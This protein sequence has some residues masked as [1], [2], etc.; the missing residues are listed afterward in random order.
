MFPVLSVAALSPR[1]F[2][3]LR[4]P[5]SAAVEFS[6]STRKHSGPFPKEGG[7][8]RLNHSRDGRIPV[9]NALTSNFLHRWILRGFCNSSS[10]ARH[11]TFCRI[12]SFS[13]V[14]ISDLKLATTD[15]FL[16]NTTLSVL[17]RRREKTN[18][19]LRS[20][21]S[22]TH[23]TT[24]FSFLISKF[25]F[26]I[27]STCILHSHSRFSRIDSHNF[28]LA[29]NCAI[30]SVFCNSCVES[31]SCSVMTYEYREGYALDRTVFDFPSIVVL[32][33]PA[34]YSC[35]SSVTRPP[36]SGWYF[37]NCSHSPAAR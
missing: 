18:Q 10:S 36:F 30:S 20:A 2:Q 1:L 28:N 15:T 33:V 7:K 34:T 4:A 3:L 21:R 23:R 24:H 14:N 25:K 16:S 22:A 13:R 31:S 26:F 27:S 5:S 8:S 29:F 37:S 19:H 6:L 12:S 9:T 11:C 17:P 32:F 35:P